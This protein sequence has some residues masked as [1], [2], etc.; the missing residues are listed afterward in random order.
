MPLADWKPTDTAAV[1]SLIGGIF[2]QRRRRRRRASPR[3]CAPRDARFGRKRGA[4]GVRR[5]PLARTT[6]R[7]RSPRRG[8]SRFPDP[9][10]G[11]AQGRAGAGCGGR[12]AV[13]IPDRGSVQR[14]RPGRRRRRRRRRGRA[15]ARA[16]V[17][18]R[19]CGKGGL[20]LDGPVLER[21][22][23]ARQPTPMSGRPLGV[24]G[25]QVAYYSPEILFELDL[26]GGGVR[27]PRRRLPRASAST[28][29]SGAARTSPGAPPRRP[30]TTWTSS[31][32][33]CASPS[34]A[35]PTRAVDALPLQGPLRA[36]DG[37]G[38]RAAHAGPVGGRHRRR[39]PRHQ[40]ASCCAP[41]TARSPARPP[42]RASRSRSPAARSTYF[43]ELDSALAF[44]R[45]NRNE[46]TD[47][48]SF[49]R[50]MATINFLFN[51]FY[52][53]ERDIA[54]LQSGWFPLRARGTDPSLPTWG[55]GRYDW[56]GFNAGDVH[57]GPGVLQPAAEGHQPAA[58]LHR[59]LE[60][61][62][63]ARAGGRP[64]TVLDFN[65]VHRSERL[66]DRVR[67]AISG[68]G[69]D[70]PAQ[71]R[72]DHGRRR[73]RRPARPGGLP[74]AAPGDRPPARRAASG[75][76]SGCSTPGP[77][78]ASHRVDRNGD[79]VYED[80]RRR[81]AHG[82]LV[83][84]A[85][86]RHLRAGARHATWSTASRALNTFDQPPGP[87][88]SAF[89]DG[90]Y[91]YVE[92]DLRTLLGQ[93]GARHATRAAT[94]AA[95]RCAEGRGARRRRLASLRRCRAI[96]VRTL[97]AAAA[98]AEA[99]Y[100]APLES[101]QVPATCAEAHAAALRP[102]HLHRHRRALH[103]R[104]SRGRTAARSSRRSR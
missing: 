104:R 69:E 94:A 101:L 72:V 11:A 5:L 58:R 19:R 6:P 45:L 79:N 22:A 73:H 23:G 40:A 86:A 18:A 37:P 77:R 16:A 24:T 81:G 96:L 44:K 98:A 68:L 26:H 54:Y 21:H 76:W 32:R 78:A 67:A 97:K 14:L 66:E 80:S 71:A 13:A 31:W 65:S 36:D 7:R 34:G 103:R 48:R 4:Q 8:A 61:Q 2:G 89:F 53:D 42:S 10:R 49:Q 83:G 62:A 90:W 15:A 88:G 43:H 17:A 28:C 99:R 100:G 64:T 92:K 85:R 63:G 3:R 59:Q 57:L 93:R 38:A 20:E 29:C 56:R 30:P 1:A 51:W 35:A 60:Q 33:S 9:K 41:C 39:G 27:H 52:T 25:P 55:T 87:G 46:V 102:D 12:R 50:T 84:A 91:G 47:A 82:R 70:R 95:A 75:G 74:V